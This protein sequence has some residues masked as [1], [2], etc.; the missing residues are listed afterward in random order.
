MKAAKL[1]HPAETMFS[2]VKE[3][4]TE[5]VSDG[6]RDFFIY[7]DLGIAK[8]TGGKVIAQLVRANKPPRIFADVGTH[9]TQSLKEL[10]SLHV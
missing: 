4:D 8:A 7:R 9:F 2:H 1:E 5:F 3:G 6:L 10:G